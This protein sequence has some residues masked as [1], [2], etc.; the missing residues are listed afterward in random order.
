MADK[1]TS[2]IK[3]VFALDPSLCQ[4]SK[5]EVLRIRIGE[6]CPVG[7]EDPS[8]AIIGQLLPGMLDGRSRWVIVDT[9]A[10]PKCAT[11]GFLLVLPC[12]GDAGTMMPINTI[13]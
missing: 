12:P 8:V 2:K 10:A 4:F 3:C 1:H 6:R 13:F 9:E 7:G 5:C 11:D